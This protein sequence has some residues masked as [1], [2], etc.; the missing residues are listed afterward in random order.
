MSKQY[1][2]IIVPPNLWAHPLMCMAVTSMTQCARM[3]SIAERAM[4]LARQGQ[5]L[6]QTSCWWMH[7]TRHIVPNALTAEPHP[8]AVIMQQ[9]KVFP[10][11]F[12]VRGFITGPPPFVKPIVSPPSPLL[13]QP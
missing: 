2:V 11:E 12:V 1:V 5:V 6:N 8:N 10:V 13:H 4:C 9:C 3:L 7:Q